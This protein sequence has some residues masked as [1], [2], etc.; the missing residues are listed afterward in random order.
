[1]A[2]TNKSLHTSKNNMSFIKWAT[3]FFLGMT[4]VMFATQATFQISPIAKNTQQLIQKIILT[5]NG[6]TSGTSNITLDGTTGNA[7]FGG[8]VG[9]GTTSP[10]AELE[11]VGDMKT[12]GSLEDVWTFTGNR[13]NPYFP[14]WVL[15]WSLNTGLNTDSIWY[16][17]CVEGEWF[18]IA[19]FTGS[20]T[21]TEDPYFIINQP[22][23][24]ATLTYHL[25]AGE[26]FIVNTYTCSQLQV[27]K[28]EYGKAVP[29]EHHTYTLT[30][31]L[32]MTGLMLTR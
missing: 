11:V 29:T 22:I 17:R 9:I 24:Y 23:Q 10:T 12:L 3:L 30:Q 19:W 6:S 32:L 25:R 20:N 2:F 7:Y 1:M 27:Q 8:N 16:L 4:C 26:S 28:Q 21:T 18:F 31:I 15:T 5:S 14:Q 13:P